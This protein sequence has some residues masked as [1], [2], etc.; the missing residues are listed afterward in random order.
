MGNYMNKLKVTC[1]S[2]YSHAKGCLKLISCFSSFLLSGGF[3]SRPGDF[4]RTHPRTRPAR[5]SQRCVLRLGDRGDLPGGWEPVHP[6]HG[7]PGHPA[8]LYAPGVWRHC[9]VNHPHSHSLGTVAAWFHP[10]AHQD[11]TKRCSWHASQHC[12]VEFGQLW[13]Q[14]EVGS[15]EFLSV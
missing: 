5:F 12:P 3:V 2:R 15:F 1:A 6:H 13:P 14:P 11:T 9:T 8:H 7:Q 10:T 4:S